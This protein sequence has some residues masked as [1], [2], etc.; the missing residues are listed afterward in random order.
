MENTFDLALK[1]YGSD[2][3]FA[4]NLNIKDTTTSIKATDAFLREILEV[5]AEINFEQQIK[6]QVQFQEQDLWH[7]SLIGHFHYGVILLQLPESFWFLFSH[8]N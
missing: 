6:S 5:L 7:N 1:H 4:G 2:N 3:V 8:A